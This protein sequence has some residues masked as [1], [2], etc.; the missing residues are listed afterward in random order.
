MIPIFVELLVQPSTEKRGVSILAH[1]VCV[2]FSFFSEKNFG[3]NFQIRR[4]TNY[5]ITTIQGEQQQQEHLKSFLKVLAGRENSL[6][7]LTPPITFTKQYFLK[8]YSIA[9]FTKM[10]QV[11]KKKNYLSLNFVDH[12]FT[13]AIYRVSKQICT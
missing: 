4:K 10:S 8:K 12:E 5:L 9:F 13:V 7:F 11:S 2:L 3:A 6:T 1:S